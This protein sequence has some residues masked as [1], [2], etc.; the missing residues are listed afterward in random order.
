MAGRFFGFA[1]LGVAVVLAGCSGTT[2]PGEQER[3]YAAVISIDSDTTLPGMNVH[4]PVRVAWDESLP[5]R[6]DSLASI[7]FVVSYDDSALSFVGT[8]QGP[9]ISEWEYFTWRTRKSLIRNGTARPLSCIEIQA[10][11]DRGNAQS[12]R[13]PQLLPDG[14]LCTLNFVATAHRGR[15]GT[16]TEVGFWIGDCLDNTFMDAK[17]DNIIYMADTLERHDGLWAPYDTGNCPRRYTLRPLL[18]FVS[19]AVHF[20]QPPAT[21]VGDINL[22]GVAQEIGD[23]ILLTNYFIYGDRVW[24]ADPARRGRQIAASDIN[25]DGELLTRADLEAMVSIITGNHDPGEAFPPPYSDTLVLS[26]WD[27]VERVTIR[28]NANASVSSV[29]IWVAHDTQDTLHVSK[30]G[31][32]STRVEVFTYDHVSRVTLIG[33]V[34]RDPRDECILLRQGSSPMRI[35]KAQASTPPGVLMAVHILDIRGSSAP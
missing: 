18:R 30:V 29:S 33:T 28:G 34:F 10:F 20:E 24:D 7:N 12:P 13:P 22:N 9:A 5:D 1:L 32:D 3:P 19:G 4:L 31:L 26:V 23:A 14:A 25:G 21:L 16:T 17:D 35:T 27:Q 15:F 11:R 6:I 2:G 8:D